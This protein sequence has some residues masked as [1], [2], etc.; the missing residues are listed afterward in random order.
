MKLTTLTK[1]ESTKRYI[2]Y[3]FILG[4]LYIYMHGIYKKVFKRIIA[5][6]IKKN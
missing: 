6:Q 2:I 1:K 3:F 5:N 4:F